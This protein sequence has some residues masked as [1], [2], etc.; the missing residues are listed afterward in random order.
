MKKRLRNVRDRTFSSPAAKVHSLNNPLVPRR[1]IVAISSGGLNEIKAENISTSNVG[2]KAWG[3][4]CL[5]VEWVPPFFVVTASASSLKGFASNTTLDAEVTKAHARIGIRSTATVIVRSSGT[6]ETITHRGRLMSARC[7]A[8]QVTRTIRKLSKRLP[9]QSAG[10]VHWIVQEYAAPERKGLLSN[11]RRVSFEKRD[12][13]AEFEVQADRPGFTEPVAIRQWRDGTEVTNFDLSCGVE[14]GITIRLKR[15]AMWAMKLLSRALF[16]WVWDGKS[17][18]IVQ[19]DLAEASTGIDPRTLLPRTIAPLKTLSLQVFRIATATDFEKF[20]K[21]RNTCIY[22][23]LGY[24]ISPF[25]VLDDRKTLQALIRGRIPQRLKS[26]LQQLTQRSLIIRTDGTNIPSDKKEMLPRSEE[27]RTASKA[28]TWLLSSLSTQLKE[29]G[30]IN[31]HICLIAHHF[32]PSL[33]SAWARAVPGKPIVRIESLW[34]IPEGLYWYSHDTYEIDTAAI[35]VDLTK[36]LSSLRYKTLS[37]RRRYKGTF[38]AA[39]DTGDWS[40]FQTLPPSDWNYTIKEK[41]WLFEIARTTR[42]V[43]ERERFPASV[44]WFIGN[45]PKA[46]RHAVLPW[47]HCKSELTE[48]LRAAPRQKYKTAR[49]YTLRTVNDWVMLQ[50]NVSAGKRINRVIVDPVDEDLIRNGPFARELA[51]LAAT[52]DFVV[53]LSGGILSHVFHI[54]QSNGARVECADLVGAQADVVEYDKLVRDKIP[55]LI[56]RRGERVD[57]IGLRDEALETAFLQKLVEE[58]FEAQDSKSGEELIG[59]IADVEEVI[60]GLCLALDLDEAEIELARREKLK[61]RGGFRKG[62]MLT[63]TASP[64]SIEEPEAEEAA[65]LNFSE[66]IP[67]ERIIVNAADLPVKPFYQRPDSR[68]VDQRVEKLFTFETEIGRLSLEARGGVK[69][70]TDFSF[71]IGEVDQSFAL[72]LELTRIE[73]SIRAV[74]RLRSMPLQLKFPFTISDDDDDE[75][76]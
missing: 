41:L 5:P 47:F 55:D 11:E 18:R 6:L 28:E 67:E 68:Q 64:H 62:V 56:K 31:A 57:V 33:A 74:V 13:V 75:L 9:K 71:P 4:S 7:Y 25:Y 37:R 36:H 52:Y 22:R 72:V 15:V 20:G 44:M 42:A 60:R 53:E 69:G 21:L 30:L 65:I 34:G 50:K 39:N 27:L 58:V 23:D 49:D 59:E 24:T 38:I 14:L 8:D 2:Y 51:Q 45:H 17:V 54:L 10:K 19:I 1:A 32:I 63:K 26:D 43:A 70:S 12:W 66:A 48:N 3:L 40:R 76:S 16:E 29:L 35:K 73:S 46:T 61:Q